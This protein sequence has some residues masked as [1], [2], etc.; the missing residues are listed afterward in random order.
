MLLS[1]YESRVSRQTSIGKQRKRLSKPDSMMS[2]SSSFQSSMSS[3]LT[4]VLLGVNEEMKALE[5]SKSPGTEVQWNC[6]IC[7]NWFHK[8]LTLRI[9]FQAYYQ[10]AVYM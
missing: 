7:R 5:L 2:S 4:D 8:M 10:S 6:L 1:K 9:S 3:D